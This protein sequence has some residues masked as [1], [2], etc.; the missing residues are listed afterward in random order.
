MNLNKFNS[1]LNKNHLLISLI[2]ILFGTIFVNLNIYFLGGTDFVWGAMPTEFFFYIKEKFFFIDHWNFN[3]LGQ[4]IASHGYM[5]LHTI[6]RLF[7]FFFDKSYFFKINKILFLFKVIILIYAIKKLLNSLD[8]NILLKDLSLLI[9]LGSGT[10]VYFLAYQSALMQFIFFTFLTN[11][12][13][14]ILLKKKS[15]YIKLAFSFLLF[16]MHGLL[17]DTFNVLL[18][19]IYITAFTLFLKKNKINIK[20]VFFIAI[21]LIPGT[22]YIFSILFPM[23]LENKSNYSQVHDV[24]SISEGLNSDY[25]I[26]NIKIFLFKLLLLPKLFL[27]L[28]MGTDNPLSTFLYSEFP[29]W[30]NDGHIHGIYIYGYASSLF[31]ILSILIYN[32]KKNLIKLLLIL[33]IIIL[34]FRGIIHNFFMIFLHKDVSIYLFIYSLL[35]ILFFVKKY[36]LKTILE[37]RYFKFYQKFFYFFLFFSLYSVIIFTILYLKAYYQDIEFVKILI[38]KNIEIKLTFLK[39]INYKFSISA[40]LTL[41]LFSLFYYLK[42]II[43]DKL[44]YFFLFLVALIIIMIITS[45]YLLKIN[46]PIH[47]IEFTLITSILFI[48][49]TKPN[50]GNVNYNIIFFSIFILIINTILLSNTNYQ[51]DYWLKLRTNIIAPYLNL[52]LFLSINYKFESIFKNQQSSLFRNYKY[53]LTIFYIEIV[54]LIFATLFLVGNPFYKIDKNYFEKIDNLRIENPNV[55]QFRVN[56][57]SIIKDQ[58]LLQNE[59]SKDILSNFSIIYDIEGVGG[60]WFFNNKDLYTLKEMENPNN[61][62]FSTTVRNLN[63]LKYL[64][65]KYYP[66][67]EDLSLIEYRFTPLKKIDLYNSY[68]VIINENDR[69]NYML[70][71]FDK[72]SIILNNDLNHPFKNHTG[73]NKISNISYSSREISLTAKN[74][75]DALLHINQNYNNGWRAYINESEVPIIRMNNFSFGLRLFPSDNEKKIKFVYNPEWS[76]VHKVSLILS[77]IS[78]FLVLLFF[79]LPIFRRY[80]NF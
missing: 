79:K 45:N 53:F 7:Y 62:R 3:N 2:I 41:F 57:T 78:I 47:P 20:I 10:V 19:V 15:K 46:L 48:N 52:I 11:Y 39:I 66:N 59:F 67:T 16:S 29:V 31:F 50:K 6:D 40:L 68:K 12:T 26:F 22:I 1:F 24:F 27:P 30:S 21:C 44:N 37:T 42:K 74:E 65:V 49:F 33:A 58:I 4:P 17:D 63:L 8:I 36:D 25:L 9:I 71:N 64:S 14:K 56:S 73:I 77:L 18:I 13:Y 35:P 70:N 60:Y 80:I 76:I 32:L 34:G 55:D 72:S 43:K 51:E 28:I 23:Y 54:S 61:I 69:L 75:T 5:P 38:N